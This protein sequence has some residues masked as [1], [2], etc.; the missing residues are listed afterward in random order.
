MHTERMRSSGPKLK[1]KK[2]SLETGKKIIVSMKFSVGQGL[3]EMVGSP[4]LEIFRTQLDESL[5]NPIQL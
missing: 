3:K 1:L 5:S 4:S 2:F